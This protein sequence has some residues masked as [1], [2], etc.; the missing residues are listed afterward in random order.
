MHNSAKKEGTKKEKEHRKGLNLELQVDG[1]DM[2][3]NE[4][5]E[6]GHRHRH[7]PFA[8]VEKE[9]DNGKKKYERMDVMR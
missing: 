8:E 3:Q 2:L 6:D 7:R 9:A 5:G 1:L 4:A